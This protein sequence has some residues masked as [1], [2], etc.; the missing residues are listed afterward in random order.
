MNVG[1]TFCKIQ[2]V[3]RPIEEATMNIHRT[4]LPLLPVLA[5]HQPSLLNMCSTDDSSIVSTDSLGLAINVTSNTTQTE[6]SKRPAGWFF[7]GFYAVYVFGPFAPP[8]KRLA[9]FLTSDPLPGDKQAF[10]RKQA[11]DEKKKRENVERSLSTKPKV[12][13]NFR[14]LTTTEKVQIANIELQFGRFQKDQSDAAV[15]SLK[16]EADILERKLER[17]L[18]KAAVT[19][20]FGPVDRLE[21]ELDVLLQAMSKARASANVNGGLKRC[22]DLISSEENDGGASDAAVAEEEEANN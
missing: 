6:V 10:S 7:H 15:L 18:Q 11:R 8:E 12:S 22:L 20:D 13:N 5:S 9:F 1:I 21:A 19:D 2:L 3:T 17:A 16:F 14:G 4:S